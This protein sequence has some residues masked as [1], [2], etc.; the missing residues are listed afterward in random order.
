MDLVVDLV[1]TTDRMPAESEQQTVL[2]GL[3]LARCPVPR[4]GLIEMAHQM[5]LV[6]EALRAL[7]GLRQKTT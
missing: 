5:L 7:P 3:R 1:A 4:A 6:R 2:M